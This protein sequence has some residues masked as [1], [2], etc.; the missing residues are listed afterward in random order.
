MISSSY[1]NKMN[2]IPPNDDCSSSIENQITS[3]LDNIINDDTDKG[4]LHFR[5]EDT[6]RPFFPPMAPQRFYFPKQKKISDS[7]LLNKSKCL[8]SNERKE[9]RYNTTAYLKG[10]DMQVEILLYE[11][12]DDLLKSEKIDFYIYSKLKGNFLN[13]IKTHKGSRIFQNYLKKTQN[14]IIHLIYYEIK[15]YLINIMCDSYGNYFCKKFFSALNKKD[16]MDFI[17]TIKPYF[18]KLSFDNVGTFP[19]QAIVEQIN[20]NYEK[21]LIM[22]LIGKCLSSFFYNAYGA[23]VLEK[24]VS[25]FEEE[26]TTIIYEFAISNF[27]SL[28]MDANAICI[29]KRIVSLQR[30]Q[31]SYFNFLYKKVNENLHMLI[32]H[33]NGYQVVLSAISSWKSENVNGIISM[34]IN[35]FA[36]LSIGKFSS[37]VVEKCI[38]KNES[39]LN[40]YIR[41]ICNNNMVGGII[42]NSYGN[43]VIQKALRLSKG[44]HEK[45]L[46]ENIYKNLYMFNDIKLISK[47][48]NLVLAHFDIENN[49]N[50]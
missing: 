37:N 28:S 32:N 4:H 31:S 34:L 49:I 50:G 22:N 13:V 17:N 11:I 3:M 8:P 25:S 35:N 16:R 10:V 44:E 19:I 12:N 46:A 40:L 36:L 21:R 5:E 24:I 26:Y 33:Q 47:W 27:L 48:K 30:E 45:L 6:L 38:E 9:R 43:Y 42:K 41:E 2:Q 20:S 39:N 18:V 23:R 29:M 7:T 1:L 15:M 14:D